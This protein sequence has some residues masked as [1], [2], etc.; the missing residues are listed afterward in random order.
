MFPCQ[1]QTFKKEPQGKDGWP[2]KFATDST[3]LALYNIQIDPGESLDIKTQYPEMVDSL[4]KI[5]DRYRKDVG[6]DLTGGEGEN[7]R[8]AAVV[9]L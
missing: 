7:V 4:S 9:D 8:A 3:G 1:F 6:D 2:G 5:A